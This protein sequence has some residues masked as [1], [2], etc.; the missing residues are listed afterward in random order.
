MTSDTRR[1][2]Q[3]GPHGEAPQEE[4]PMQQAPGIAGM[5]HAAEAAQAGSIVQDML[6]V[7]ERIERRLKRIEEHLGVA[8]AEPP[9][10]TPGRS[11]RRREGARARNR[12]GTRTSP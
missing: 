2:E 11:T 9:E 10:S 5:A 3:L 12:A 7:L 6:T 8:D 1:K 4:D